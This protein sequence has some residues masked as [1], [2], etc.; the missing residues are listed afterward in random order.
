MSSTISVYMKAKMLQKQQVEDENLKRIGMMARQ[1][2]HEIKNPLAA[3]WGAAQLIE[4]KSDADK[5][6]LIII[7]EE[8][9]RL[10]AILDS[11]QDFSRELKVEQKAA[12]LEQMILE[13]VNFINLQGHRASIE[14]KR[15]QEK[16][17]VSVD[18]EKVKQVMLN[19]FINA[20][21]A[22]A[23]TDK[24][25]IEISI[26]KKKRFA[27]VKVRDNGPG[28]KK[29]DLARVKE[30]LYTTKPKG[31]GLG[32]AICER[33]MNAHKGALLLESDGNTYTEVTLSIPLEELAK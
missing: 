22:M 6:N 19:V 31:S 33:I 14:F 5:E 23:Y 9:K 16:I 30:P 15:P 7:K 1:M 2:A 13:A 29:E 25:A 32:L 4:G 12:D 17:S 20:I 28:I 8:M 18:R 26:V 24:P 21:D 10:T 11:W 27:D 3:L